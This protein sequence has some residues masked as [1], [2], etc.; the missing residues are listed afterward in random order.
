[1][2]TKETLLVKRTKA[3]V[4][5]RAL[6]QRINRVLA[7]QGHAG[8]ALKK[9]RGLQ[10]RIDLGV[11]W[12]LDHDRNFVIQKFVN[13]EELGRKLGVLEEWEEVSDKA[14]E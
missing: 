11:W 5:E 14:A 2:I 7:Q 1:L 8:R 6:V 3:K 10:A 9:T 12:V 4:T 13:I